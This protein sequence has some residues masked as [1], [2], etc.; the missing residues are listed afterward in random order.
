MT[1]REWQR[2]TEIC[3][4]RVSL[5]VAVCVCVRESLGGIMESWL[6]GVDEVLNITLMTHCHNVEN[7]FFSL[8]LAF[9]E[10]CE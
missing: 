1:W 5:G 4:Y 9:T 8:S 7:I 3:N 2:Q 6:I 10:V